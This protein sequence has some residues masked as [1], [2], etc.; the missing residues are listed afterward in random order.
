M[1]LLG[2]WTDHIES[3]SD[4]GSLLDLVWEVS[5]SPLAGR[6]QLTRGPFG[7]TPVESLV[8]YTVSTFSR[9]E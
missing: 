6:S 2:T 1:G 7:S 8:V 4:L 9:K 5:S 3:S